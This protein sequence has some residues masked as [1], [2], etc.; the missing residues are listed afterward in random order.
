MECQRCH[1][2]TF[3]IFVHEERLCEFCHM[4][5]KD[6]KRSEFD[7]RCGC[8]KNNINIDFLEKLQLARTYAG[9]PFVVISGCR[10]DSHNSSAEVGGKPTSDHLTGEGADIRV[11]NST[12]RFAILDSAIAAGFRRI[13]IGRG[14]I[15]LGNGKHNPQAVAW[16]Y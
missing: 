5:I 16:I 6:F 10:C 1:R 8:G 11:I 13:G 12:E 3:I 15:H 2:E 4:N 9:I 14:F 7:C